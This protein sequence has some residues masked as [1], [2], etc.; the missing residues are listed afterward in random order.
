MLRPTS[1]VRRLDICAFTALTILSAAV[2][3]HGQTIS[4][5]PTKLSFT[6]TPGGASPPPQSVSLS[7]SGSALDFVVRV[8]TPQNS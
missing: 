5:N 7:S 4:A 1:S 6:Y 2:P 3:C 8:L